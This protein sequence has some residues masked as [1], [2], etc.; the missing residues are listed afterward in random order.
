M[1]TLVLT[2]ISCTCCTCG[3]KTFDDFV[4]HSLIQDLDLDLVAT[5]KENSLTN[6]KRRVIRTIHT[7]YF[8]NLFLRNF[9]IRF[10]SMS[11]VSI[12]SFT[13][14]PNLSFGIAIS[15]L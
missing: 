9:L 4:S 5:D 11:I 1:I 2:L 10:T 12:C 6:D 7:S 3:F 8:E 13:D 15:V 14:D